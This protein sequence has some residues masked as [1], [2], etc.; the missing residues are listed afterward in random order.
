MRGT[1]FL[2]LAAVALVAACS[3]REP[4]AEAPAAKTEPECRTVVVFSDHT[5]RKPKESLPEAWRRFSGV[6][7]NAGWDG[8]WC[9]DLYVLAIEEDG[10]VQL[11]DTHGPGGRHDGSAFRRVGKITDDNRLTFVA[12][13]IRREYWIE[14]DIMHGVRYL[15][16]TEKSVIAMHR[17]S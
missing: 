6:W 17:K 14:N 16:G 15:S 10:T 9:H 8:Y 11:I 5:V 7:G 1:A 13:G 3:R 12:D 4:V 2:C